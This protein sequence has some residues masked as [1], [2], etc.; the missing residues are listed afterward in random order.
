M[1]EKP[2]LDIR[3]LKLYFKFSQEHSS[4]YF[5][6]SASQSVQFNS[7]EF[8]SKALSTQPDFLDQLEISRRE[9][10][11]QTKDYVELMKVIDG[12]NLTIPEGKNMSIIGESGCGKT[13]LLLSIINIPRP[14]LKY[15]AGEILYNKGDKVVDILSLPYKK[16]LQ[17]RGLH[18]GF[19][20]QLAKESINP[21]LEVGFQTGEILSDRLSEKQEIIKSKVIE[22]LGKVAFPD[23]KIKVKKYV[24][25]LS[26]GEAQKVVIAMALITNPR[27]LLADEI[28]SSL[29]VITQSQVSELLKDLNKHLPFQFIFTTHNLASAMNLSNEI[30]VM[31]AGEIV[32]VTTV[33]KFLAEPLHPYSQG[34]L[35][36]APWY[37]MRKGLELKG[38]DGDPPLPYVWPRGCRF[39]PR[40][41]KAIAK[42]T[43]ERPILFNVDERKVACWLYSDE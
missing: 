26:G 23:P 28:F 43:E 25:Q 19:I 12:V 30:A 40:C 18:F 15:L 14:E 37:A 9:L 38:I 31:H 33:N 41:P 42:C 29:D 2:I 5:Y 24:H 22:Y 13:T 11:R 34:L 27:I 10:A 39:S 8:Y 4:N 1:P 17:L 35:Q 6:S 20:P 7:V 36:S 3:D 21:L 16:M 32:E